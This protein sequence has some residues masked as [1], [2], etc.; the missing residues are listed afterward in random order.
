MT[1]TEPPW[2][3][4]SGPAPTRRK[5]GVEAADRA[6][7]GE[8]QR[9]AA[10]RR[11]AAERHDEGRHLQPRDGEALQEPPARPTAIGDE[12]APATRRSRPRPA[13]A[14]TVKRSGSRPWRRPRRRGRQSASSEPTERSMPAVR[15]TKVMPTA[16][17]P[18]IDTCRMT[19]KR[20]S[21][22]RKRGSDDGEARH[23]HDAGRSAARSGRGTRRRRSWTGS[24]RSAG[25]TSAHVG[26]S[27]I[28]PLAATLSVIMVISIS[29]LA[30]SRA[31][32]RP[33]RAP[34][35]S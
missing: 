35:A 8:Q 14:P 9:G 26:S 27:P 2:Q 22:V 6:A 12:R 1:G 31:R 5:S 7:A 19:L 28:T 16:S 30:S 32:S 18:T 10:E 17:R 29:S 23:Q 4:R 20:L 11:H 33:S 3:G 15:M 25:F 34:R 13:P 21:G 24:G